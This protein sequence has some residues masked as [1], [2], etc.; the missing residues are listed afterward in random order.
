MT[1]E[2]L[3]IVPLGLLI[4][5]RENVNNDCRCGLELKKW[6]NP[7]AAAS[8]KTRCSFYGW[9]EMASA[10]YT[11]VVDAVGTGGG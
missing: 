11:Y 9:Q 2:E 8:K 6:L 7:Y 4:Q 10:Q 1:K 3:S 5:C